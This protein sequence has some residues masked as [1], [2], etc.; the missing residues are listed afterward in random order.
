MLLTFRIY[1]IER[2]NKYIAELHSHPGMQLIAM[3]Y[4][5]KKDGQKRSIYLW[6]WMIQEDFDE[7]EWWSA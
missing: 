7:I 1:M 6:R 2:E 3:N 5:Q 4:S